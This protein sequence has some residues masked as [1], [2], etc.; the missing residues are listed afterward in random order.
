MHSMIALLWLVFPHF[1]PPTPP[2]A[3]LVEATTPVSSQEAD[4]PTI[5]RAQAR[6]KKREEAEEPKKS[7]F[8]DVFW[9]IFPPPG[10]YKYELGVSGA[11]SFLETAYGGINPN[12]LYRV[13]FGVRPRPRRVPIFGYG[14]FDYTSYGQEAG[15]LFYTSR[16]ATLGVGGGLL[17]YIGPGA[18]RSRRRT[19]SSHSSRFSGL[20]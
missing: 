14:V 1:A 16:Y 3:P 18:P 7:A 10:A 17:K 15:D 11:A 9:N 19:R 12:V 5:V 4:R 6:V 8:L 13:H 2:T 20:R